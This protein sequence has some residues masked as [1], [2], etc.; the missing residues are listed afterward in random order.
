[1]VESDAKVSVNKLSVKLEKEKKSNKDTSI[2]DEQPQLKADKIITESIESPDSEHISFQTEPNPQSRKDETKKLAEKKINKIKQS[3][4]GL[5]KVDNEHIMNQGDQLR[6]KD[7]SKMA[8]DEHERLVG[9]TENIS[10]SYLKEELTKLQNDNVLMLPKNVKSQTQLVK[11]DVIHK[12]TAS[13]T[14]NK[15]QMIV[16]VNEQPVKEN[17]VEDKKSI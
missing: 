1:M 14:L 11:K 7:E 8:E 13:L 10:K 2:K 9:K 17:D 12:E 15:K 5:N 16:K 4:A 6:T 3:T